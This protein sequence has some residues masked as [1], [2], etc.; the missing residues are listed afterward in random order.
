ML[1]IAPLLILAGCDA[2]RPLEPHTDFAA[3]VTPAGVVASASGAAQRIR[4]GELWVLAFNAKRRADGTSTGQ[5][6]MDRKDANVSFNIDVTCMSVSG[7]RAWIAGII[8]N[9]AG[10][11]AIDGTI[12]YFYVIDNG[13][14]SNA[15][16]DVASAVRLN[17]VA[18][19][20]LEFCND[21]PL[22]LPASPIDH[23]NVQ[24]H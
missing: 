20:D 2:S 6:R 7:N 17:D 8:R 3:N 14:G 10:N 18:G 19:E 24:V 21:Q 22:L 12:S 15:P 5:V 16:P 23:G 11:I 1:T 4:N 9:Q 13:E